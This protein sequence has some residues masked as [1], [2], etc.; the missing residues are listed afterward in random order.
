LAIRD[1][2][3][4]E[5]PQ[6][7]L[8]VPPGPLRVWST[9]LNVQSTGNGRTR[10]F[11][12]AYLS[13]QISDAAPTR[14][15]L[16]NTLHHTD[17]QPHGVSVYTDLGIVLLHDDDAI[18]PADMEALDQSWEQAWDSPS[19]YSEVLSSSG[20]TVISCTTTSEKTRLPILASFD[21]GNRPVA[22]HIDFGLGDV[23]E[24]STRA[25]RTLP[26]LIRRR[27]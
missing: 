11:Q 23:G 9:E 19:D 25:P 8:A 5:R 10:V 2:Y 24:P 4:L 17:V 12:P 3:D 13:V 14:V 15:G 18:T 22:I 7:V 1:V 20:A 21:A 16:P 26:R 27:R 6:V